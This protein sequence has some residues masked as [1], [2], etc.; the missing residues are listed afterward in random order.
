[1]LTIR[2]IQYINGKRIAILS[3]GRGVSH[4]SIVGEASVGKVL[5]EV[6][7]R[8]TVSSGVAEECET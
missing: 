5:K 1:M 7:G 6:D 4:E 2:N 3:D 8:L